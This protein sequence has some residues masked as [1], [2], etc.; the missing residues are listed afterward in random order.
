MVK[1]KKIKLSMCLIKHH[2]T[3]RYGRV[4]L[5]LPALLT[6]TLD[7]IER[8]VLGPGLFSHCKNTSDNHWTEE[9]VVIRV[10]LEDPGIGVIFQAK[11]KIFI[12]SVQVWGPHI[13]LPVTS[14]G[15]LARRKAVG[16]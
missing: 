13:S 6:S 12:F 15:P 5:Q 11:E 7:V 4:K 1:V 16:L 3:K 2:E 8:S 9:R 14:V 10:D